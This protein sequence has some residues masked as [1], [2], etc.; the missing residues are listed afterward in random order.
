MAEQTPNLE[1]RLPEFAEGWRQRAVRLR[2]ESGQTGSRD[3]R[4]ADGD[5]YEEDIIEVDKSFSVAVGDKSNIQNIEVKY[6]GYVSANGT[7]IVEDDNNKICSSVDLCNDS[8]DGSVDVDSKVQIDTTTGFAYIEVFLKNNIQDVF[9]HPEI[10]F[11]LTVSYKDGTSLSKHYAVAAKSSREKRSF[12]KYGSWSSWKHY[13]VP[14][15]SKIPQ[16]QSTLVDGCYSGAAG[17]AW[18]MI[19]GY[20]DRR[21]HDRG[22]P[23]LQTLYRSSRDGFS[24]FNSQVRRTAI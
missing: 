12:R 19:F 4:D 24:G 8:G 14:D 17:R 3:R 5:W 13:S 18:A 22:I 20:F 21:G 11:R 1:E 9:G 2:N 6:T 7:R 15:A 23:W 16:Y 10:G